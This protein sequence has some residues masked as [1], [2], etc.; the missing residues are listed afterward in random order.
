LY[1]NWF[2]KFIFSSTN[3]G[4]GKF[5]VCISIGVHQTKKFYIW[6]YIHIATLPCQPNYC[7][8]LRHCNKHQVWVF[9]THPEN[10]LTESSILFLISTN[11]GFSTLG[12]GVRWST[13][14]SRWNLDI[15]SSN[16]LTNKGLTLGQGNLKE[17]KRGLL[18]HDTMKHVNQS[19][20]CIKRLVSRLSHYSLCNIRSCTILPDL[21]VTFILDVQ[22]LYGIFKHNDFYYM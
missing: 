6:P 8:S 2:F 5:K 15:T 11:L 13:G 1:R 21:L 14:N 18:L 20:L 16:L 4:R 10:L 7:I 12:H 3:Q 9:I 22:N 19:I 17:I